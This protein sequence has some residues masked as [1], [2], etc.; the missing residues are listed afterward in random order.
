MRLR[1]SSLHNFAPSSATGT[2]SSSAPVTVQFIERDIF[3][4]PATDAAV[5]SLNI[6]AQKLVRVKQATVVADPGMTIQFLGLCHI[7]TARGPVSDPK[8]WA[9]VLKNLSARI[10]L[11]LD[12]KNRSR[13]AFRI[14]FSAEG[15]RALNAGC[16]RA[17]AVDFQTDH[18]LI[19][20]KPIEGS[21]LIGVTIPKPWPANYRA[22]DPSA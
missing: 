11:T 13:A 19:R 18:G 22:C 6:D 7:C 16:L 4:M 9:E 21:T 2:S 1:S 20:A 10:P 17:T 14:E 3:E 15:R 12:P 5:V 8:Q